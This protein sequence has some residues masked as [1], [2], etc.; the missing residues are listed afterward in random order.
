M[1]SPLVLIDVLD[2]HEAR[3]FGQIGAAALATYQPGTA[4]TVRAAPLPEVADELTEWG[5]SR[6][7]R[8]VQVEGPEPV[9]RSRGRP[10]PGIGCCPGN[11][12]ARG[13]SRSAL[14][15]DHGRGGSRTAP[16]GDHT[17]SFTLSRKE[18]ASCVRE[19]TPT[20]R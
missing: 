4:G 17:Q 14:D 6:R 12:V 15:D 11:R 16:G 20:L 19:R 13:G 1:I 18:L 10:P 2:E 5:V 9:A 8:S 3:F 7:T